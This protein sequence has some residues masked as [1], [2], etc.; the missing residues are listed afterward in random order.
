M[1]VHFLG[2]DVVP[3][4]FLLKVSALLIVT[5]MAFINYLGAKESGRLGGFITLLKVTIL[6]IFAGFGIYKTITT[7]GWSIAFLSNPSFLPNG[8]TGL[9]VAMGLT[10]IA[11]E[12]YEIIVQSGEEVKN[13]EKNIPKAVMISLW[14]AVVIYI[15]VAFALIGA[16][17]SDVP[18]WVFL[19]ELGEFSMIRVAD[20][21]MVFGS[22]LIL[23]G[24]F[25]STISAMNATVY[26]SSRV[27][28]ALGRMGF[29]PAALSKINEKHCTPHYAILFSYFIIASMTVFPI[30]TVASVA[31]VMFLILFIMVNAVL[32]VLRLRR[33][34]LKRAFKMPLAPYLPVFA[35]ITQAS[36]G[37]F[38]IRQLEQ[39][40]FIL[41][42]TILWM[43]LGSFIFLI[44]SEKSLKK[45]TKELRRKVYEYKPVEHEGY[46]ILVPVK[47]I[48]L[49]SKL[50]KFAN[51][52]AENRGGS[53]TFLNIIT[54]PE[55]TPLSAADKY[56]EQ[57]KA[58]IHKLMDET[59]VPSGG[60][61]KVGR[62][63][64]ETILETIEEEKPDM[65]VMGWRGRTYRKD[66]V[67]GSTLDPILLKARCD[68]VVVR[69]EE[70]RDLENMQSILLPTA[71]G[72]HSVLASELARE[73]AQKEKGKI[74]LLNV[75]HSAAEE[76]N[77][78]NAF[79][80]ISDKFIGINTEEKFVKA[81]DAPKA[82][83]SEASNHDVVFIGATSRPFLTNF[84][85][86]VFPEKVI[87]NTN[88]TVVMTRKWV[89][90]R[91]VLKG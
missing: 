42:I 86:G 51:S 2:Y 18:S 31:N 30:E 36:I 56:V 72:P 11:F 19:G 49:A 27:V 37:Y 85:L 61:I 76:K 63:A 47:N 35:I 17:D 64:S 52:I 75:G 54:L 41:G 73:L 74:T 24:G 81:N 45:V 57:Q 3:Q 46:N 5:L 6:V 40:G 84:L 43:L 34:D 14:T 65:L 78:K 62:K 38:L 23:A 67:L 1:I 32:V 9:L 25:V 79:K 26:S 50:T 53:I 66:F 80:E 20:T 68:V 29:L 15:L 77:A 12:G 69:F 33:P 10:F 59:T 48:T 83:A 21:I 91:D 82:I 28:F 89:K 16:I 44:Y 71:G 39:T 4:S 8:F 88:R 7:P 55:Q 13:P 58:I 22:V 70:G 60:I 90:F 87:K